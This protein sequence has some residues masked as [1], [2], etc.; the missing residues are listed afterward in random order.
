MIDK[1]NTNEQV[2]CSKCNRLFNSDHEYLDHFN[3]NHK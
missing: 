2:L 3:S 1:K